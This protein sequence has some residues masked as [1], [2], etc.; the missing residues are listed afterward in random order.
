[1]RLIENPAVRSGFLVLALF[2]LLAGDAWRY[3]IGWVGFGV[4][5]FLLGAASVWLLVV[6]RG[7][8]RIAQLPYPL[9]VF[10]LLATA[11]LAWSYYPGATALGLVATWL[12]IIAAVAVAVTFTWAE[13]LRGLGLALRIVL[14]LSLLFE[15]VTATLVRAPVLPLVPQPGIDYSNLPDPI[16]KMLYWSRNELFQVFDDGKIQGI[17]G[18]SALLS[19]VALLAMVVFAI[20]LADG[21]VKKRSGVVW[22]TVAAACLFFSRSA[23]NTVG[24]V[25][26]LI[27]VA[28]VLL[29]RRTSTPRARAITYVG[30]AAIAILGGIAAFVLRESVFA[31]LGKSGDLTN[32]GEIWDAVIALA[33][34]R[35]VA[36]WGWVSYW[37]PWVAPFD[38]LAFNNG[39]RQLHA[40]NAWLDIWLQLGILGLVVF[41]CLVIST[42]ARV[43][44]FAVDRA[45]SA[46]NAP[47]PY[48]AQ[49]LL[50]LLIVVVLLVQSVAESRLIVEYGLFLLVLVA[51]KSKQPTDSRPALP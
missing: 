1:M 16:P 11:S 37:V 25:A 23:T 15:L 40:H 22:L 2:T 50:P 7:R 38:D 34:Q 8:W 21:V 20:Q 19:F 27:V 33:Q 41:G 42:L 31:L 9:L 43:W 39:V 30:L 48:T 5:A 45:Q 12:T 35:P 44:S 26:A 24:L 3:T 36:G 28:A 6:Q 13:I 4:L 18:N 14:A 10:L 46:P 49:A 17:V 29:V 32:R 47:A 51:V